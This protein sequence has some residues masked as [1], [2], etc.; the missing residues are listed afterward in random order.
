[1]GTVRAWADLVLRLRSWLS[2]LERVEDPGRFSVVA[3]DAVTMLIRYVSEGMNEDEV[4]DA[5][6]HLSAHGSAT[7]D[8]ATTDH[9]PE[10]STRRSADA[11]TAALGQSLNS[12]VSEALLSCVAQHGP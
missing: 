10:G 7:T 3:H 4:L 5:Q 9:P 2:D 6:E 8:H 12:V 11:V 1:M